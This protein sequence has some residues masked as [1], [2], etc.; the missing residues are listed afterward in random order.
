MGTHPCTAKLRSSGSNA[1]IEHFYFSF[2]KHLFKTG[3]KKIYKALVLPRGMAAL[4]Y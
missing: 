3:G 4:G 2:W 1:C